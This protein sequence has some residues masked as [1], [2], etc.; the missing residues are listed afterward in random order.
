MFTLRE[1]LGRHRTVLLL[2]SASSRI[3]TGLLRRE[4]AALWES[5]E[6]DA[7]SG[8]FACVEKLL[9]RAGSPEQPL[10][11]A[12]IDAI[13]F[14]DGPGSVLGI[15][16]AAVAL[17]TWKTA[18]SQTHY[19][20]CSLAVVGAFLAR[21]ENLRSFSVIADA[22]RESWHCLSVDHAGALGPLR[23]IPAAELTGALVQPSHFR[24]WSALP[25]GVRGVP[26]DLAVQLPAIDDAALFHDAP[27]PDAFLHEEPTYVTWTPQIHRAPA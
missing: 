4:R 1:L 10:H 26:Y 6:T 18:Y 21:Q 19:S 7:G 25:A 16:T 3:Q 22:R 15:R 17:R 2:D 27:E 11:F 23:R 12:E 24:H 14:C 13:L 20:Y 5:A 8:L 9:A